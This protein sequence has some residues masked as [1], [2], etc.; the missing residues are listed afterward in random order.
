MLAALIIGAFTAWYLGLRAGVI[1]AAVSAV[2]LLAAGIIPG[3]SLTVYL[4]LGGWVA[5]LY[6]YGAKLGGMR[7]QSDRAADGK[8]RFE[9]GKWAMKA[10]DLFT[11]RK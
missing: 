10:K 3:M 7:S 11:S 4:V 5:L 1:A 8:W 6:F 9:V 2:A